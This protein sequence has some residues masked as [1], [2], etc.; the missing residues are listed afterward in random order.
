MSRITTEQIIK[1]IKKRDDTILKFIYKSHYSTV[2][3]FIMSNNG[4]EEDAQDIFQETLI[5]VY[6][7]IREKPDF[8]LRCNFQTYIYSIARLFWLKH[9][10]EQKKVDG[11]IVLVENL[12][13]V[14]FEDPEP[15]REEDH[16]YALYQKAFLT[17]P[18]DCRDILKMTIDGCSQKEIVDALGLTS[19]NYIRKRKHFC[20]E[21]LIKKI[22]EDPQFNDDDI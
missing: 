4:S 13:Y 21:F 12:G 16:R 22:K 10:R 18:S 5:T 17:L 8:V 11:E 15:F 9:L 3:K 14:H 19:E 20:K 1:G 6:K 7:N 2:L